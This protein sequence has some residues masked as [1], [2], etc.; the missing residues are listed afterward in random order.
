MHDHGAGPKPDKDPDV[1]VVLTVDPRQDIAHS[2]G[3]VVC[4]FNLVVIGRLPKRGVNE[5]LNVR[6]SAIQP[7][8]SRFH[9]AFIDDARAVEATQ[10]FGADARVP[11]SPD[12]VIL[13]CADVSEA[14]LR[15]R[16][17]SL[18]HPLCTPRQSDGA[19]S[20]RLIRIGKSLGNISVWHSDRARIEIVRIRKGLEIG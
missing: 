19:D 20:E 18:G 16:F 6:V 14:V 17:W 9:S 13:A 12:H 11:D 4:Q 2:K 5:V 15:W 7:G 1:I 10:G 3:S 8:K